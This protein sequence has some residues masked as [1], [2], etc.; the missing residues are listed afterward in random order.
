VEKDAVMA[1]SA[2]RAHR[3][4]IL[5][6]YVQL[7]ALLQLMIYAT[8]GLAREPNPALLYFDPRLLMWFAEDAMTRGP[9]PFPSNLSWASVFAFLA[10]GEA[11]V[12]SRTGLVAY[13]LV[14]GGYALLFMAFAAL[15]VAANLSPSHGFSVRE[16]IVPLAAFTVA[17]AGP[18]LVALPLWRAPDHGV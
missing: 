11:I 7:I 8:A 16:L 4:W 6:R 15:I 13:V 2:S 10:L 12:Q 9:N 3:R 1:E 17:S 5:G 14:E 18:L